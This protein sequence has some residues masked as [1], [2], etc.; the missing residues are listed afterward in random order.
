MT[1]TSITVAVVDPV[2][3]KP[4]FVPPLM[5][6]ACRGTSSS[7]SPVDLQ[8]YCSGDRN[9]QVKVDL[10]VG[11]DIAHSVRLDIDPQHASARLVMAG[12]KPESHCHYRDKRL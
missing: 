6:C 7:G 12:R 9:E 5:Y 3:A 10:V 1:N 2:F 4:C 11:V 8:P